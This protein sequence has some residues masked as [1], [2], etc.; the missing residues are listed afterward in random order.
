ME[1]FHCG[2]KDI[3]LSRARTEDFQRLIQFRVPVRCRSCYERFHVNVFR[4]WRTGILGSA[5]QNQ[6][7][8]EG[9]GSVGRRKSDHTEGQVALNREKPSS[10]ASSL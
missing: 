7:K 4:A 3:R 9:N 1:C 8:R 10:P 2:S 5:L 6:G